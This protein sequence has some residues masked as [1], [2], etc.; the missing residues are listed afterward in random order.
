MTFHSDIS[1]MERKYL[2]LYTR[3]ATKDFD[4]MT[5]AASLMEPTEL[6]VTCLAQA[7]QLAEELVKLHSRFASSLAGVARKHKARK[8]PQAP[9]PTQ[10]E[11]DELVIS[12][13]FNVIAVVNTS[14][15]FGPQKLHK[16]AG[17]F[18]G[19]SEDWQK[20]LAALKAA[21]AVSLKPDGFSSVL[22]AFAQLL[23]ATQQHK[24]PFSSKF[25]SA[26]GEQN[27]EEWQEEEDDDDTEDFAAPEDF[28]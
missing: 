13:F 11:I 9:Y 12:S 17:W 22:A 23:Y 10:K 7:C 5:T 21:W 3:A 16:N 26:L 24:L 27:A 14:T 15:T 28:D 18:S 4:V 1:M 25:Y 20:T 19:S 6:N 2:K 8:K